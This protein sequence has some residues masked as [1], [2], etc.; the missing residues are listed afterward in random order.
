[1]WRFQ[2]STNR[3]ISF[4]LLG[5]GNAGVGVAEDALLGIAGQEDQNALLAAAAA[6]NIVL[7]QRFLGGVGGHGM[8]VQIQRRPRRQ[9][10]RVWTCSNQASIR[11]RLARWSTREL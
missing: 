10:G 9:A 11:R 7:F 3:R 2:N 8:E 6:G 4:G 5:L 1:M